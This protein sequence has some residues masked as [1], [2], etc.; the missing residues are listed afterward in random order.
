MDQQK[1]PLPLSQKR[2]HKAPGNITLHDFCKINPSTAQISRVKLPTAYFIKKKEKKFEVWSV[3]IF[4]HF[5]FHTVTSGVS[6]AGRWLNILLKHA[7]AG[8]NAASESD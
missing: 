8:M 6:A 3:I 4:F 7:A 5:P 2:E 1:I